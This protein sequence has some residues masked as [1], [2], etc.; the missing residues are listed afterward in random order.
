MP[1]APPDGQL[2][3]CRRPDGARR[4]VVGHKPGN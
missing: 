4:C 3:I 2:T 1:V